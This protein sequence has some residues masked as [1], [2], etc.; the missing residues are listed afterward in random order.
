MQSGS[1]TRIRPSNEDLIIQGLREELLTGLKQVLSLID[2]I[3]DSQMRLGLQ[4]G[5]LDLITGFEDR[6]SKLQT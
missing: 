5:C 2:A 6:V 4:A 1:S 3:E